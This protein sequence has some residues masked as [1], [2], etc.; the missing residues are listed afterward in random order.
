MQPCYDDPVYVEKVLVLME[1]DAW[2]PNRAEPSSASGKAPEQ[3][4]CHP[5]KSS[6][7]PFSLI[8]G[9]FVPNRVSKDYDCS[10]CEVCIC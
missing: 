9:A 7:K 6:I 3:M 4:V 8:V 2:Y 1:K 5:Q 10:I